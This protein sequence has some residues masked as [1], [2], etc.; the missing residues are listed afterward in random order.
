MFTRNERGD[1][2]DSDRVEG[3]TKQVEGEAQEGW[4]KVKDKARDLKDD[5]EDML[6]DDHKDEA[7]G[8]AGR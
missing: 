7:D 2:M 3:K 6:R 1:H 5:A 4:G 8:E